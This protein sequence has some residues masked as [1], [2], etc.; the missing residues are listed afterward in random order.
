METS[1]LLVGTMSIESPHDIRNTHKIGKKCIIFFIILTLR[2]YDWVL[3]PNFKE[4]YQVIQNIVPFF[5]RF[6]P[7]KYANINIWRYISARF[8]P[9]N[10]KPL[11]AF[12]EISKNWLSVLK[13]SLTKTIDN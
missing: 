6:S 7:S 12:V 1:N 5:S 13:N 8:D 2:N 9:K 3:Q 10:A 4:I 11:Y